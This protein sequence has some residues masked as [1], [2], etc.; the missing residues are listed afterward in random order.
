MKLKRFNPNEINV[1]A[2]GNVENMGIRDLLE[3]GFKG[4]LR[5]D[6]FIQP[7]KRTTSTEQRNKNEARYRPRVGPNTREPI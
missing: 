2:G 6:V 7:G 4:V 5:P 3:L 1:T